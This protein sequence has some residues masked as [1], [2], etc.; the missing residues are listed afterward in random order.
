MVFLSFEFKLLNPNLPGSQS[1]PLLQPNCIWHMVLLDETFLSH[2]KHE[3]LSI[4]NMFKSCMELLSVK[5]CVALKLP[6]R[7]PVRF[8]VEERRG[9]MAFLKFI[10]FGS[11]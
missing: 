1:G 9:L 5:Q 11:D 7:V 4:N 3:R 2:D 10:Y 8:V 6:I